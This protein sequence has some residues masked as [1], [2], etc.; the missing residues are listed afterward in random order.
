[1][2]KV[3]M[4]ALMGA[5]GLLVAAADARAQE[6]RIRPSRAPSYSVGRGYRPSHTYGRPVHSYPRS[7]F[8]VYRP[9]HRVHHAPRTYDHRHC[10]RCVPVQRRHWVNTT[11]YEKVFA[12][13]DFCGRPIY[14]T[15]AIP[16]GTWQTTTV[17]VC[18]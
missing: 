3:L 9:D 17:Y 18:R 12:G 14:R 16:C 5:G 8:S 2:K 10:G 4:T 1:M 11:R 13:F 15:I 7:T 6:C